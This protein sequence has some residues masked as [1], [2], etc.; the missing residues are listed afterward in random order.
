MCE[1]ILLTGEVR[2]RRSHDREQLLAIRAGAWKYDALIEEADRLDA[3]CAEAVKTSTLPDEVDMSLIE[4]F[5][6]AEYSAPIAASAIAQWRASEEKRA[7]G[8][9]VPLSRL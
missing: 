4:A 2:V 7:I 5:V 8:S 6:V 3:A 1:E 9:P